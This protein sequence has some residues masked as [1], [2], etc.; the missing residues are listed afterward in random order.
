M[1]LFCDNQNSCWAI[2]IFTN[3]PWDVDCILCIIP[4]RAEACWSEP[5]TLEH[6]NIM[7][8]LLIIA[9]AWAAVQPLILSILSI[10]WMYLQR[11]SPLIGVEVT[12]S[13]EM[14]EH[15]VQHTLR[16]NRLIS[17]A[18]WP[19]NLH[20]RYNKNAKCEWVGSII[21]PPWLLSPYS[22]EICMKYFVSGKKPVIF[23]I[24]LIYR[25]AVT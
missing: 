9:N 25:Y 22:L 3:D 1:F 12:G 14:T 24:I 6:Q 15:P 4:M 23:T 13:R 18:L 17:P 7:L 16:D 2:N 10:F 11:K 20:L 21:Y 8:C 19:H 5:L